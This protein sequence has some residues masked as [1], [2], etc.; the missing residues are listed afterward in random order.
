[1][2]DNELLQKLSQNLLEILDDDEYCDITIEVGNDPYVK[3][4]R[5]HMVILNYRST[6]LRRILS[7]NK[8]KND[9]TLVQIKLPNISPDIFQIILRY[10]YG[11]KLS[12]E[13]YDTLDIIKILIAANELSLQELVTRLQSFLITNKTNW[14]EQNFN[15][16]YQ[17]SFENNSFL[18]L[19]KYCTNLISEDPDKIFESLDFSKIPENLLSSII[20]CDNL[21]MDEVQ[22]WDHTLKWGLAQNPG[23]SSDHS[24]Y[25]KD[26][27]NS[28]KNTLQHCI[29]F[30]RFYNLTS[31][32]FSDKVLPYKKILP[33]ELYKDLLITFLNLNPDSK[34]IGK[35]KPRKTK[36]E[37]KEESNTDDEDMG[38]GLFD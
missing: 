4:F 6:Y 24:T 27:F 8:K 1:M 12:L 38:F 23:L 20:Q 2:A 19:Q 10:L 29:P 15:L 30:I 7:T 5:A 11:G 26:D 22:I 21:Q 33:K 37:E 34:P 35:S 16:I 31:K 28:L 36:L 18:E 32:E 17:T 9:G 14:M 3:I 13:E 25:S